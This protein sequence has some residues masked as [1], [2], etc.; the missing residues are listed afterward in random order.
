MAI[1]KVTGALVD[2]GDLDL[3]NVGTLHLDSIVSDASPAVIT[4]G[5]GTNDTTTILGT[6][7]IGTGFGQSPEVAGKLQIGFANSTTHDSDNATTATN[8]ALV[9]GNYPGVEAANLQAGIQFNIHGGNQNRVAQI[10]AVAEAS[11][12]RGTAL[13][14]H[15]DDANTRTEKMRISG[16]GNIGIGVTPNYGKV[17]ITT[18]GTGAQ[19][20]ALWVECSPASSGSNNNAMVVNV[21]NGNMTNTVMR[22]HHESPAADQKL[23][24]L[25]TTGSNTEKFWVD[26][27]GD[28]YLAGN[29]SFASGAG[30]SFSATAD[31]GG[32]NASMASEILHDYEEGS[33]TPVISAG[34]LSLGSVQLA[35]YTKVGDRV[36]LQTYFT[37]SGSGDTND[38]VV[39]GLPFTVQNNSYSTSAMDFEKGPV[40]S[41]VRTQ[42]GT[43]QVIA[44]YGQ[45]VSTSRK[46]VDGNQVGAGYIIF[47]VTYQTAQ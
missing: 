14:F 35:T 19:D 33:W 34:G 30:I 27:D 28:A 44:L 23:L 10:S 38:L 20:R 21:G 13:V 31:A 46:V 22:I 7:K 6:T 43:E 1:T 24:S 17:N 9:I 29:L 47:A 12:S 4:V 3:T 25:D 5:Y 39:S 37:A 26:E 11:D 2:I 18:T 45:G 32:T 40:G 36:H 41:Y 42:G 8:S 15:S 16:A